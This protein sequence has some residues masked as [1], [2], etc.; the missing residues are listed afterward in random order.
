LNRFSKL[1]ILLYVIGLIVLQASTVWIWI[2]SGMWRNGEM[3]THGMLHVIAGCGV[4]LI[5]HGALRLAKL[6]PKI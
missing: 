3:P 4:A 5:I 1:L 6:R 2:D